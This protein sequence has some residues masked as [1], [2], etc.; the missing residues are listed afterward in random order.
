MLF[1]PT[2]DQNLLAIHAMLD[3]CNVEAD[4]L[5]LV[6]R[7]ALKGEALTALSTYAARDVKEALGELLSEIE[8]TLQTVSP[9]TRTFTDL[10]HAQATA[11]ALLESVER[12]CD[13]LEAI[14]PVPIEG[15]THI[16]H[17]LRLA[18][19]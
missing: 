12:S 16:S 6:A 7:E 8:E 10:V 1:R 5:R 19:Q 14:E 9:G 15:P 13:M 18:A 2:T 4:H 11:L 3:N 17:E